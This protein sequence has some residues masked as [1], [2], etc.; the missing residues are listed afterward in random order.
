MK[1]NTRLNITMTKTYYDKFCKMNKS[2]KKKALERMPFFNTLTTNEREKE[3][4]KIID[5]TPYTGRTRKK[6]KKTNT[7][8]SGGGDAKDIADGQG[9][10]E[11]KS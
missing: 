8:D 4:K 1:L 9:N 3:L 7:T 5:A 10:D 11:T 6:A 2:D